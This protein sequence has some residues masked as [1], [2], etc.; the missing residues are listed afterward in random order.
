ME[1]AGKD[2][3]HSTPLHMPRQGDRRHM[4]Y[5]CELLF[6]FIFQVYYGKFMEYRTEIYRKWGFI[7]SSQNVFLKFSTHNTPLF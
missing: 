3:S 5:K 4:E 1:L 2:C 7:S 6:C